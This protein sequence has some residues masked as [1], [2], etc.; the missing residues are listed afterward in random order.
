MMELRNKKYVILELIPTS[1]NPKYGFIAQ[2]QA[3]KIDGINLLGRFDYRMDKSKINNEQI[4]EMLNY[5]NDKF[6]YVKKKETIIN[7]FK[8]FIGDLPLLII[9]ND[10]TKKYLEDIDNK[11]ESI[12]EYFNIEVNEF[13]F[14]NLIKKYDLEST[15]HLV[16]LLY[17]ALIKEL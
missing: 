16:D 7:N 5:D 4:I 11:K 2:M 13:S 6:K 9:D 14:D 10:Y 17:E 15:N 12:F 8:K 3:L 1:S